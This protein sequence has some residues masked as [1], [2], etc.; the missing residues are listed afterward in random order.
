M[1][2]IVLYSPLLTCTPG[3]HLQA[4]WYQM[5]YN[6]VLTSWWWWIC[7]LSWLITKIILRCT[8]AKHQTKKVTFLITLVISASAL[9]TLKICIFPPHAFHKQLTHLFWWGGKLPYFSCEKN[10]IILQMTTAIWSLSVMT[11]KAPLDHELMRQPLSY[12]IPWYAKNVTN[13]RTVYFQINQ[14]ISPLCWLWF[15]TNCRQLM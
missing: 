8:A 14:N 11:W 9:S 3:D 10:G 15:F 1:V 2:K 7:A 13:G 12:W 4:W 6:T 5:L